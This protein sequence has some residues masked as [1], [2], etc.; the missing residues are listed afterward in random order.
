M[1]ALIDDGQW[2]P[3]SQAQGA[4]QTAPA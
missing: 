4:E 3:V 1:K 2:Q